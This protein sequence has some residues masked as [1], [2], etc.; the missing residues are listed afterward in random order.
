MEKL[1]KDTIYGMLTHIQVVP[2]DDPRLKL[3]YKREDVAREVVNSLE[4]ATI[5]AVV[6]QGVPRTHGLSLP[7]GCLHTSNIP[8]INKKIFY[9][10]ILECQP[11]NNGIYYIGQTE[12]IGPRIWQH[13]I[14]IGSS[15]TQQYRPCSLVH[16]EIRPTRE[17]ALAR[18]AFLIKKSVMSKY[19][20]FYLPPEL[21][22][23]FFTV[24]LAVLVPS[25]ALVL[26]KIRKWKDLIVLP[27]VKRWDD[28]FKESNI[29]LSNGVRPP[30]IE[31][32]NEG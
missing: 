19:I 8:D 17:Q 23:F 16:L 3:V 25:V 29:K 2:D 20:D 22:A 15:F 18:E 30:A 12:D 10:Y 32:A 21:R 31:M 13:I 14:G 11:A 7:Q 27:T 5:S 6:L 1:T 28:P 26:F 24:E 4:K 9:I